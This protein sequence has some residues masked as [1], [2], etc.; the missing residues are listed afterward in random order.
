M[1]PEQAQTVLAALMGAY[2]RTR[3]DQPSVLRFAD[4]LRSE[5][6]DEAMAAAVRLSRSDR[7][8]PSLA[9]LLEA[10]R[11]ERRRLAEHDQPWQLTEAKSTIRERGLRNVAKIKRQLAAIP[12]PSLTSDEDEDEASEPEPDRASA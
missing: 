3:L 10:I 8:F 1:T 11:G 12:R 4:A 5:P 6:F 2:P 9:R 7:E